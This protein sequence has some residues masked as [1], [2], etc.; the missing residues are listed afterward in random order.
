[1]DD[2]TLKH[3]MAWLNGHV[4]PEEHLMVADKIFALIADD[5]ELLNGHS[6]TQLR[7]MARAW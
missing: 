2:Y 7:D 6:W 5:P 1:M 4:R 3:F